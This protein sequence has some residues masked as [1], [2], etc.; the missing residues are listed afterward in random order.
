MIKFIKGFSAAYL[1]S[2]AVL[3]ALFL[4]ATLV[5]GCETKTTRNM[6]KTEL[7]ERPRS[8]ELPCEYL[9]DD[10]LIACIKNDDQREICRKVETNCARYDNLKEFVNRTWSERDG[11]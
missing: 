3:L 6:P 4:V 2:V 1:G 8:A 7:P 5:S 9:T 11:K 10:E